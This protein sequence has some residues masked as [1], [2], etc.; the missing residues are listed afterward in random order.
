MNMQLQ[1]FDMGTDDLPSPTRKKS[2]KIDKDLDRLADDILRELPAEAAEYFL[3]A[4][5][6]RLL[7]ENF[8]SRLSERG[9][10]Q[11]LA[12]ISDECCDR[13]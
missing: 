7:K 8:L 4:L 12:L 10:L 2:K 13:N 3:I 1:L 5:Q 11:F 9:K 6:V